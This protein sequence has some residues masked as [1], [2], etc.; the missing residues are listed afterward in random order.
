MLAEPLIDIPADL[1]EGW[2]A[3]PIPAGTRCLVIS[4]KNAT[5]SRLK[6]GTVLNKFPSAL[7]SGAP[8]A[9]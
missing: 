9:R 7:P 8:G 4:A 6:N 3:V 1:K 2:F 5:I